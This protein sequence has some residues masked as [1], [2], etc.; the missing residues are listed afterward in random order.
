MFMEKGSGGGEKRKK[1]KERFS[2]EKEEDNT[3]P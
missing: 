1:M 2:M 3:T